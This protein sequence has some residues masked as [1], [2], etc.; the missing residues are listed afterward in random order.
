MAEKH[1]L[2]SFENVKATCGG[3]NISAITEIRLSAAANGVPQITLSV[4]GGHSNSANTMAADGVSL[5]NARVIFDTCRSLVKTDGGMLK[6][7]MTCRSIGPSGE[8]IQTLNL[9]EWMLI[10]VALSPV[11][12][13]G[14][15][16]ATLT[17]AH[18]LYKAHLGGAMLGLLAAQPSLAS[19]RGGNPLAV[20]TDALSEYAMAPRLSAPTIR[21]ATDVGSI[22]AALVRQ[23]NKALSALEK[24]VTWAGGGL[25]AAH[26]LAGW[27]DAL[28]SGIAAYA[29][30]SSGNS[31]LQTL[32]SS[33]IPECML[34]L[35]GDFTKRA[36]TLG[37]FEPWADA[38]F[39]V[40]DRDI[41]SMAFPQTDPAPI[42]G[43]RMSTVASS[44]GDLTSFNALGC[45]VGDG[46]KPFEIFY[47]PES[48]LS[49]P[50]MY[51]PI[52]Q[53]A[54]PGW[55][56]HTAAYGAGFR[57][58]GESDASVAQNGGWNSAMTVPRGGS[59]ELSGGSESPA[60]AFAAAAAS[61]ARAYFET[62][63]MKDW[64]FSLTTR[65]MLSTEGGT[66]CP[67][68][69]LSVM[70]GSDGGES[71]I[72]GGYV[73]LVEHVI[74]VASKAASTKIVC[75]HP[76][77]GGKLPA[78]ITSTTNALYQ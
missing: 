32:L 1:Y 41:V 70:A 60:L 21:G 24:S 19:L 11:Q 71:E 28:T 36:L 72:V 39:I 62:S 49:A 18:P 64:G 27:D 48:E 73:T 65:F 63:F 67:G 12:R 47:V 17:F 38:K 20:F 15:C 56:L 57:A 66:L 29:V 10:D 35:G 53:F 68:S 30:P 16:T 33:L 50:Y 3:V 37:P 31:V 25:P 75:S 43:V 40:Y 69:V 8:D 7:S 45:Q 55:L 59:V 26:E 5:D 13:S 6:L 44:G 34:A 77:F 76:R 4:D 9:D 58:H 23:L 54:E 2:V 46:A 51:G 52:Q 42:S 78:A 61:C 22:Q 14:V 74:S